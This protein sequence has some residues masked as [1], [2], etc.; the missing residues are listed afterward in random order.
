MFCLILYA[1]PCVYVFMFEIYIL[2]LDYSIRFIYLD[3]IRVMLLY[4]LCV[5][6]HC[7]IAKNTHVII[8]IY[9]T[10]FFFL[11][12]IQFLVDGFKVLVGM[13]SHDLYEDLELYSDID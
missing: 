8:F 6:W 4:T 5:M 11:T 12:R 9:Q 1:V 2:Y 7:S 3:S 13:N 10:C